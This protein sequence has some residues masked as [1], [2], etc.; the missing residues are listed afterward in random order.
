MD[1][2]N[3]SKRPIRRPLP[4]TRFASP[5][6][7]PRPLSFAEPSIRAI[8]PPHSPSAHPPSFHSHSY[9]ADY[10]AHPP[11]E[12]YDPYQQRGSVY[13]QT[14]QD[15]YGEV[16]LEGYGGEVRYEDA[17]GDFVEDRYGEYEEREELEE[18]RWSEAPSVYRAQEWGED[19][20]K[21]DKVDVS[22][23][24]PDWKEKEGLE[25][26]SPTLFEGVFGAP[27]EVS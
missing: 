12:P 21:G 26:G 25:E 7:R 20:E 16:P 19:E 3:Y 5:P 8:T 10:A 15:E 6:P 13:Q 18:K 11:S 1:D 2:D 17:G 9:S 24:G 4:S 22:F 23:D 14:Q 27:P